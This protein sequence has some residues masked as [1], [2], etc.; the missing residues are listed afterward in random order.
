MALRELKHVGL[1]IRI[2]LDD[3]PQNPCKDL[4][5]AGTM[6]CFHDRYNL[7][8]TGGNRGKQDYARKEYRGLWREPSDFEEWWEEH[9]VGGIR[10][11]LRLYDHS[12]L[13]MS[14]G[15]GASPFD[16]GGWDSG[17]VGWIFITHDEILR[18]WTSDQEKA[19]AC[20]RAEVETYDQYLTGQV[21]GYVV[22]DDDGNHLDSCYGFFGEEE[23]CVGEAKASAEHISG[24]LAVGGTI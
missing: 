23:Y 7:G 19:E 8:H 4:D 24:K 1:R 17:Q 12:G 16:S 6:V 15:S 18:E 14:V 13:T 20:L 10:L 5:M 21:Y 9:G 2:E 22:E 3:D 11:P